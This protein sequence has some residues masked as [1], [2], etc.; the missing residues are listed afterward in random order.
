MADVLKSVMSFS[1]AMSV[2]SMHQMGNL[3]S[4]PEAAT[5]SF[6]SVA[7]TVQS[8]MSRSSRKVF[9]LGDSLQRRMMSSVLGCGTR[10]T[11][12]NSVAVDE[13]LERSRAPASFSN[14][15]G[16]GETALVLRSVGTGTVRHGLDGMAS[17]IVHGKLTSVDGAV[18][19]EFE[20]VWAAKNFTPQA[21]VSYPEEPLAPFDRPFRP[22]EPTWDPVLNP[23]KE[24]WTLDAG[25]LEA[26]GPALCRIDIQANGR[27]YFWYSVAAFVTGG[28]G[29]YDG[30]R[31]QAIC[32][33]SA[34]FPNPP[35]PLEGLSFAID[36]LHVLKVASQK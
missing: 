17:F 8:E 26:V 21:L 4:A 30:V 33:G 11:P 1:W 23:T 13:V 14:E 12:Q 7:A 32:L 2:F 31:G 6:D 15:T 25:W 16:T 24:K 34:Q 5:K 29:A 3:L 9:Q 27:T 20:G 10:G 36:A 18:N 35:Q 19:G 22:G 28:G